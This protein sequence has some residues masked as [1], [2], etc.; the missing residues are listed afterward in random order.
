MGN[1][2]WGMELTQYNGS[3]SAY[4]VEFK[5]ESLNI[6][7]RVETEVDWLKEMSC[8]VGEEGG[9]RLSC[10]RVQDGHGAIEVDAHS[11]L[12]LDIPSLQSDQLQVCQLL[13]KIT[14][15]GHISTAEKEYQY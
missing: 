15:V 12:V 9:A 4:G 1:G 3:L 8:L 2:E 6:D 13:Q 7:Q 14:D 5:P 10:C 11:G